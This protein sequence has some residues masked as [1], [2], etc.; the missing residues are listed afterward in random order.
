MTIMLFVVA[1]PVPVTTERSRTQETTHEA[2][3]CHDGGL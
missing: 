2:A 3:L 1:G